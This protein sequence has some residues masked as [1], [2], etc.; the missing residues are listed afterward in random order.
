MGV[1][2]F[3]ECLLVVCE[4]VMIVIFCFFMLLREVVGLGG[5]VLLVYDLWFVCWCL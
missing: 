3:C 4:L 1:V 5:C 2:G